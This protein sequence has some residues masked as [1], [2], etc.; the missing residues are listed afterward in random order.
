MDAVGFVLL[1]YA[2]MAAV[3]MCSTGLGTSM[4]DEAGAAVARAVVS[5]KSES[6]V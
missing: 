5:V 3:A 1:A 4:V 2:A 6:V